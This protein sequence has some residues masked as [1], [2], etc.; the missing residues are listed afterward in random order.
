M[1]YKSAANNFQS[2][3]I[4]IQSAIIFRQSSMKTFSATHHKS[5][6]SRK[7]QNSAIY[8]NNLLNETLNELMV[9]EK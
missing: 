8:Q 1:F 7:E 5:R 6:S 4:T 3:L 2:G 9:F